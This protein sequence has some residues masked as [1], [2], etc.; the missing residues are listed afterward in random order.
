[1]SLRAK[2]D[3]D[4]VICSAVILAGAQARPLAST[5]S[6]SNVTTKPKVQWA[7]LECVE[8]DDERVPI[9]KHW[10]KKAMC[11]FRES[12][13]FR[14]P[15]DLLSVE[16]SM[17]RP[18]RGAR[19]RHRVMNESRAGEL[20]RWL[21]DQFGPDYLRSGSGIL[22]VAGGKG[23]L[24]F[25]FINLSAI[26]STVF[27]PRPL[28]LGRYQKKL[29][30]GFYHNNEILGVYNVLGKPE[31]M[32]M[33]Q[34][35]HHIRLF[36]E[37]KSDWEGEEEASDLLCDVR[38]RLPSSLS[39]EESFRRELSRSLSTAWTNK[40]LVHEEEEM[41]AEEEGRDEELQEPTHA[42]ISDA[43]ALDYISTRD[44]AIEVVRECSVIVGMHPDQVMIDASVLKLI[45]NATLSSRRL[46]SILL[47]SLFE[48]TNH[49]LSFPAAY[50]RSNF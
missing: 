42:E 50:T 28:E 35:P 2:S 25:E 23:E 10:T 15:I 40:G 14:H 48:T 44:A 34:R 17:P 16:A 1:M 19:L 31:S 46:P 22:D 3:R 38:W 47:I 30:F 21:I 26:P 49:S 18:R 12:C 41:D 9:C 5:Y 36:F 37:M 39:S 29:H 6:H 24:S 27:D 33:H 43:L 45:Y 4:C 11:I 8:P 7:H 13:L 32:E 20:R